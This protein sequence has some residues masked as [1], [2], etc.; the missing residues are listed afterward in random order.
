LRRSF[1]VLQEWEAPAKTR[2]GAIEALRLISKENDD[3]A[4][5]PIIAP[6]LAA[7]LAYFEG[8]A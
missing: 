3:F 2:R 5:S 6:L 1:A 4:V 8:E 7:A